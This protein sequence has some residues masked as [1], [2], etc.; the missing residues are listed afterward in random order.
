MSGVINPPSDPNQSLAAYQSAAAK[1]SSSVEPPT[2]QGGI[3][4]A[5]A[6]ATATGAAATSSTTKPS[7]AEGMWSMI[8]RAGVVA[9]ALGLAVTL[10]MV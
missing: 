10:L 9:G 6:T 7:A 5:A 1:T 2:V 8:A 3:I 4:G